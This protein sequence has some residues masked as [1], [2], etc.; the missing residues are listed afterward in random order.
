MSSPMSTFPFKCLHQHQ[1]C[2]EQQ[3]HSHL[4][5]SPQLGYHQHHQAAHTLRHG[6][7]S[8]GHLQ[9]PPADQ[10]HLQVWQD[11][12]RAFPS[13]NQCIRNEQNILQ[14]CHKTITG[15]HSSSAYFKSTIFTM[16][17]KSEKMYLISNKSNYFESFNPY[18][19]QNHLLMH[20][21][22]NFKLI[23]WL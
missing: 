13:S 9:E 11:H 15:I 8:P 22:S 10:H 20:L 5:Q 16:L 21:S 18:L 7:D 4:P 12:Y 23:S 6:C 19:L 1:P 14:F 3:Y 17:F 2:N